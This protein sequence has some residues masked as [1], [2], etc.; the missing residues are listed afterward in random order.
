MLRSTFVNW[1]TQFYH[2]KQTHQQISQHSINIIPLTHQRIQTPLNVTTTL[3]GILLIISPS[4]FQVNWIKSF[5]K[6]I[7]DHNSY[8]VEVCLN[9]F[10]WNMVHC[11]YFFFISSCVV[12]LWLW[13]VH[14]Y[15]VIFQIFVYSQV[16]TLY[17]EMLLSQLYWCISILYFNITIDV[18]ILLFFFTHLP[19]LIVSMFSS[20]V[21]FFLNFF[22]KHNHLCCTIT[23]P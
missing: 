18:E 22:D 7:L 4:I 21:L 23:S 10:P 6:K 14:V 16:Y 15:I 17:F 13:T 9:V 2:S 12:Q 8:S 19:I 3:H 11:I 5:N 20:F 1:C